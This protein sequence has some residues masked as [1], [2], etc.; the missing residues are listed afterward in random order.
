VTPGVLRRGALAVVAVAVA[1]AMSGCAGT[2]PSKAA[3]G[4][5]ASSG[6]VHEIRIHYAGGKVRGDT[7]RIRVHSGE[8]VRITVDSD[9]ADEVHVHGY[10]LMGHVA[11]G[12]PA[13]VSFRADTPGV[14][15]VELEHLG[16]Q[17]F[18]FQVS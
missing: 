3:T 11:P 15:E 5:S 13:T 14:F 7:G 6:A 12:K 1:L 10:N 16:R 17:L 4:S 8:Q 18:T 9:V 2:A